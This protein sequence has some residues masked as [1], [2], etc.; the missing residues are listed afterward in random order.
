LTSEAPPYYKVEFWQFFGFSAEDQPLNIGDHEGDWTSVQL[1]IRPAVGSEPAK[2]VRVSLF[3][4]GAELSFDLESSAVTQTPPAPLG[5]DQFIEYRGANYGTDGFAKVDINDKWFYYR[6][7]P[8]GDMNRANDNTLRMY[9][10]PDSG[11]FS[12]PIVY[13][14]RGAHEF[15]P[16][17]KGHVNTIIGGIAYHSTSHDGDGVSFLTNTPINLGE[18]EHPL[19][20]QGD[21]PLVLMG[22]GARIA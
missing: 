3:L 9:R 6:C 16:T 11:E 13:I 5:E 2:I 20:T 1:L 18:V 14:E 17:E 8:E 21:T 15:W 22:F 10:D 19:S 7:N 4:H 12:H